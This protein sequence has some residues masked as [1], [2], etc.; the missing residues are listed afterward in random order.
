M[1]ADVVVDQPNPGAGVSVLNSVLHSSG[2]VLNVSQ[3]ALSSET[4]SRP[5]C[6]WTPL[7][8]NVGEP[9]TRY[10]SFSALWMSN[11]GNRPFS[12]VDWSFRFASTLNSASV[13]AVHVDSF[14]LSIPVSSIHAAP[15]AGV[16]VFPSQQVR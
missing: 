10:L 5:A 11:L 12:H 7:I 8:I 3:I 4:E 14:V 9:P 16:P 6:D 15:S 1:F 2:A 13:L